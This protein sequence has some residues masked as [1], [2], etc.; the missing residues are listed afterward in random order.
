MAWAIRLGGGYLGRRLWHTLPDL[1]S[2]P[3]HKVAAGLVIGGHSHEDE[4][5]RLWRMAIVV[6][7]PGRILARPEGPP[8]LYF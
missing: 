5:K 2:G 1:A 3:F 7:T 8:G 4:K 6:G